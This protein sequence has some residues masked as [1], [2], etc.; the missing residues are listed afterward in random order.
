METD[1][2]LDDTSFDYI[3]KKEQKRRIKKEFLL[4]PGIQDW[5]RYG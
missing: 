2:W 5:I 1:G 3:Q 4:G